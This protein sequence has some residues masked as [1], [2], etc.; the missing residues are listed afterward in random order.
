MKDYERNLRA[1]KQEYG[2]LPGMFQDKGALPKE[3][4]NQLR[5]HKAMPEENFLGSW[6]RETVEGV[7]AKSERLTE[8]A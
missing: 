3:D 1:Q 8:E 7:K 4:S 2:I 6:L 5:E